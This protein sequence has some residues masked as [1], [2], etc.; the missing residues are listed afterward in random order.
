MSTRT[1]YLLIEAGL[2]IFAFAVITNADM[3]SGIS[4]LVVPDLSAE[5]AQLGLAY[6]LALSLIVLLIGIIAAGIGYAIVAFRSSQVNMAPIV[7]RFQEG[8]MPP[9]RPP[10]PPARPLVSRFETAFSSPISGG[11]T[12]FDVI[13]AGLKSPAYGEVVE[14]P[15]EVSVEVERPVKAEKPAKE[16]PAAV[17]KPIKAPK[18]SKEKPVKQEAP[19]EPRPSIFSRFFVKKDEEGS[20]NSELDKINSRVERQ[21]KDLYG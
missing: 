16:K 6:V 2:L 13:W 19:Q 4:G 18:P 10:P 9:V 11:R 21:L 1:G 14:G 17:E 8:E 3:L 5:P 20:V 12:V 15:V 7:L